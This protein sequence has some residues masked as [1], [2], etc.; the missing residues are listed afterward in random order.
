[1][2]TYIY[3]IDFG[4]IYM[5]MIMDMDMEIFMDMDMDMHIMELRM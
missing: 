3:E 4:N 5:E 1:M 2:E